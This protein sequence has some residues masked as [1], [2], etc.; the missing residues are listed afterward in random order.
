MNIDDF[1]TREELLENTEKYF[2][3]KVADMSMFDPVISSD[4]IAEHTKLH[5]NYVKK[6]NDGDLSDFT[7]GGAILH[8][9]FFEQLTSPQESN[10][11]YD[12]S[13]FLIKENFQTFRDFKVLFEDSAMSIQGSGWIYLS[14]GGEIKIIKNHAPKKDVVLIVDMWEHAYYL[15]YRTNKK[16]YLKNIW[17]LIDWKV[18]NARI[19]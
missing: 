18:I 13:L 12:S 16:E 3:T 7:V 14:R 17:N 10:Q 6:A 15:D 1:D 19:F 5:R 9:L 4:N 2:Q 11:P 8:N